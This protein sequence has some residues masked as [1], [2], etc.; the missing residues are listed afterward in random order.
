VGKSDSVKNPEA[1]REDIADGNNRET[2][3]EA[4][5]V[6]KLERA[7]IL[8][9]ADNIAAPTNSVAQQLIADK[10][11]TTADIIKQYPI[12]LRKA[13]VKNPDNIDTSFVTE[14]SI[15]KLADAKI[16][17]FN[18]EDKIFY[19]KDNKESVVNQL[20]NE[21]LT[22]DAIV[23]LNLKKEEITPIDDDEDKITPIPSAGD[24][25]SLTPEE[26]GKNKDNQRREQR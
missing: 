2:T 14:P 11:L 5:F 6:V 19:I 16:L 3:L 7:G 9:I 13:I 12:E 20:S 8:S 17:A 25:S 24:E 23:E 26:E 10:D 21:N 1:F 18:L 4:D 22:I 15:K